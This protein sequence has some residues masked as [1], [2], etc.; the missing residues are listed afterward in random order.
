MSVASCKSLTKTGLR[1]ETCRVYPGN[2]IG[3]TLRFWSIYSWTRLHP[4]F[5]TFD[6]FNIWNSKL[7]EPLHYDMTLC[8]LATSIRILRHARIANAHFLTGTNS[9][10]SKFFC[11]KILFLKVLGVTN[12]NSILNFL[13]WASVSRKDTKFN[14]KC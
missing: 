9:T 7:L 1:M 13:I 10:F 5:K 8:E 3:N 12:Q 6:Q 11:L 2:I 4:T 14:I